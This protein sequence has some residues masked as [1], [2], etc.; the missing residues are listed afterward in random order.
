MV[1]M[2]CRRRVC[3][4]YFNRFLAVRIVSRVLSIQKFFNNGWVRLMFGL[5]TLFSKCG[6]L[7]FGGLRTRLVNCSNAFVPKTF[8]FGLRKLNGVCVKKGVVLVPPGA[9][10]PYV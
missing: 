9:E 8:V 3:S 1:C 2:S 4:E 5:A 10:E 6:R 7:A